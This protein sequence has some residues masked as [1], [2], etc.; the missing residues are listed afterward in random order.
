MKQKT[1][2]ILADDGFRDE[3]VIY[4]YYRLIEAG[5]QVLI[6][7]DGKAEVRG[8]FGVPMRADTD[9]SAILPDEVDGLIVPGGA[10]C[11]AELRKKETVIRLIQQVMARN[12]LVAAICHGGSVLVSAGVVTGKAVTGYE[13]IRDE[14]VGAGGRYRDEDVVVDRNIITSR[15]PADLPAFMREILKQL[16]K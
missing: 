13:A 5:H 3:E 4:P 8:K 12:K 6:A 10:R 15:N 7:T 9:I 14:L 16:E 2:L 1:V 11:P